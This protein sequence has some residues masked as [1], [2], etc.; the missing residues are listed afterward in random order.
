MIFDAMDIMNPRARFT[1]SASYYAEFPE[2][3]DTGA[4]QFN[5]EY[6]DPLSKTYRRLY[7]NIQS[8]DAGEAAIRTDDQLDYKVNGIVITQ[9]GQAFKIVQV[10]KDY[11]AVPKQ[12]LR[13]F[14]TPVSV[15][16]VLRMITIDNPWE[17]R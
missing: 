8:F 14:G 3:R 16:Y 12:T 17:I 10:A 13:L 11:Q 15:T 9:D 5:Y 4:R 1:A 7:G 2:D 6:V